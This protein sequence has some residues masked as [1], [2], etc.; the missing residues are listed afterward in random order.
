MAEA[1]GQIG[2]M[3]PGCAARVRGADGTRAFVKAVGADLNPDTPT[4]FRREIGGVPSAEAL[5]RDTTI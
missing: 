2:G 4:L 3:S 1:V 5:D